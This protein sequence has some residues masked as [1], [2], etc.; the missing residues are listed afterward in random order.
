MA[1][2]D[3]RAADELIN[4]ARATAI[5]Y[6]LDALL[7]KIERQGLIGQSGQLT[8]KT[9]T[10]LF[11]PQGTNSSRSLYKHLHLRQELGLACGRGRNRERHSAG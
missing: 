10:R 11:E 6:G 7:R 9:R 5:K 4:S 8:S 1:P 2:R 3:E